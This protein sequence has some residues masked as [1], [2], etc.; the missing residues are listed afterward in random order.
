MLTMAALPMS[1]Q[2]TPLSP[3]TLFDRVIAQAQDRAAEDYR[4]A[5][6]DLP[7]G[8]RDM[9][10]DQYRDIRFRPE[11]ALW[12]GDARFQVQFFHPGFLFREPVDVFVMEDGAPREYAFDSADFRYE[13][14]TAELAEAAD[15]VSGFAG[16]RLHYPVNTTDYADEV[17]AFLGASYFRLVGR[18]QVYGLS[19]R[20]LA[21]NTATSGGEEFPAF[22]RFWLI[23][24]D[25]DDAAMTVLALMDSP[26]LSGAYRFR[27][28]V[29]A[30][31]T[32]DV[33][34][35]LF[36]R[37]PVQKLGVAPLTS[38]FLHGDTN[39]H[40]TDDFRPR[41]HDSDGLLMQTSAGEWIWRPL[42]NPRAVRVT[43]LLDAARPGGFG[44]MQRERRFT[45]YLDMEADYHR[46]PSLWVTPLAGDWADGHV[47]LVEIP[48]D[49]EA[50]DNIVAY[51]VPGDPVRAGERL[52]FSYRLSTRDT[53]ATGHQPPHV[54][55]T[56]SGWGAVP[57]TEDPPSREVR[58][59]IVDFAAGIDQD[60]AVEPV[61]ELSAGDISDLHARP[62]PDGSG[63]RASFLLKPDGDEPADMRLYLRN[64][65]GPLTE[66][67]SYVWYPDEH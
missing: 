33:D 66:T 53:Q 32:V 1:V 45:R 22:R 20:G 51:W 55:R 17:A 23:R 61:L 63:W 18:G 64:G 29:D 21:I 38:M 28:S 47:E 9:N 10:Y 43:A 13:G 42:S 12:R 24:P 50:A 58:R 52:Q 25:A 35:H 16:L 19:A 41:V 49:T 5:S 37:E 62:L 56:R 46:R 67:W 27:I 40:R 30:S 11:A 31:T 14:D 34:A 26:S 60:A 36:T 65:D 3:E 6:T 15:R 39:A 2:A 4:P 8:L 59:F 7:R 44:L 48:T 54:V 57:G